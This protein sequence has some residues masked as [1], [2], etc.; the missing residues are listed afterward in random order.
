MSNS[1]KSCPVC[2]F[3]EPSDSPCWQCPKCRHNQ[4]LADVDNRSQA[5]KE[6]HA[7]EYLKVIGGIVGLVIIISRAWD[8]EMNLKHGTSWVQ[9]SIHDDPISFILVVGFGIYICLLLIRSGAR[10]L[11][12]LKQNPSTY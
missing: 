9:Y 8:G 6:L 10:K 1:I 3:E 4:I 12:K 2:G 5:T 11:K 7:W